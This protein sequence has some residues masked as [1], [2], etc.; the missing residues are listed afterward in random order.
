MVHES[1]TKHGIDKLTNKISLNL[2]QSTNKA[3]HNLNLIQILGVSYTQDPRFRPDSSF[4]YISHI[5]IDKKDSHLLK[6]IGYAMIEDN[7]V[8]TPKIYRLKKI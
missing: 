2:G 3:K 1:W 6:L 8:C 7:I 4:H 5:L